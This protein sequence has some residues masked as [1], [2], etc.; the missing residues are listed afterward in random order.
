MLLFFAQSE[1]V[2]VVPWLE[3]DPP[4]SEAAPQSLCAE[5]GLAAD[6][7]PIVKTLETNASIKT[8]IALRAGRYV[9]LF[10]EGFSRAETLRPLANLARALGDRSDVRGPDHALSLLVHPKLGVRPFTTLAQL[11]DRGTA[12]AETALVALAY[13][14][15]LGASDTTREMI[16]NTLLT[17]SSQAV[18]VEA[19][20]ASCVGGGDYSAWREHYGQICSLEGTA[21]QVARAW[22]D[23]VLG[24]RFAALETLKYL[25]TDPELDHASRWLIESAHFV[26]G[27]EYSRDRLIAEAERVMAPVRKWLPR[28]FL[29]T[30]RDLAEATR[31]PM[32][33]RWMHLRA[34]SARDHASVAIRAWLNAATS[35]DDDDFDKAGRLSPEPSRAG[36]AAMES[37]AL[38]GEFLLDWFVSD[39]PAREE[40]DAFARRIVRV[41]HRLR[42]AQAF[43]S[44][45]KTLRS[46]AEPQDPTV[47][48]YR[49]ILWGEP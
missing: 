18:R 21:A 6:S 15:L 42:G 33:L 34:A 46:N 19:Q 44:L 26:Q 32:G 1:T 13:V 24:R 7:I 23:W 49:Q 9:P 45:E 28:L 10:G 30:A 3:T 37:R 27:E 5:A 38:A 41:Y 2:L 14:G 40:I 16:A 48:V 31:T 11:L 39:R 8:L 25:A 43:A 17:T 4:W 29:L 22:F 20:L 36:R 47:A 35:H 12:S